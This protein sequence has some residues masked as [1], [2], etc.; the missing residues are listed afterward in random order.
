MNN[1]TLTS[2]CNTFNFVLCP[3]CQKA[4]FSAE[5]KSLSEVHEKRRGHFDKSDLSMPK[6]Q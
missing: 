1:G 3:M 2:S 6:C 5:N 4:A